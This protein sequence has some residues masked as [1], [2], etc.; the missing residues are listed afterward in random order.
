MLRLIGSDSLLSSYISFRLPPSFSE[1]VIEP[2]IEKNSKDASRQARRY[3]VSCYLFSFACINIMSINRSV[4][5]IFQHSS[6]F[7]DEIRQK[8]EHAGSRQDESGSVV[9]ATSVVFISSI[10]HIRSS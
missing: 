1:R 7:F 9:C 4:H 5:H 8:K 2:G 6:L 10:K 3:D